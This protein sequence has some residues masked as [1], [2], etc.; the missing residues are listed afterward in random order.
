MMRRSAGLPALPGRPVYQIRGRRAPRGAD[1]RALGADGP[2]AGARRRALRGG[3]TQPDAIRA[4]PRG[5]Q[6]SWGIL[7]R[8][9]RKNAKGVAARKLDTREV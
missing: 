5:A 3:E 9:A 7:A 8:L 2:G 6:R 4:D 1:F